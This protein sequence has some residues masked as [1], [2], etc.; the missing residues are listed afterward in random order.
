MVS[1]ET[2]EVLMRRIARGS[3]FLATILIAIACSKSP[4]PPAPDPAAATKSDTEAK[5]NKELALYEQM[6]AAGSIDLAA[7]LGNEILSTYPNTQAAAQVQKTIGDVRDKAAHQAD[8][9]RLSRL[10]TYNAVP[11]AGGT[12]YSAAIASKDALPNNARLRLVL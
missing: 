7:N 11:E 1:K 8:A 4:A 6:R 9:L 3:L 10:W 12:Q 2:T 5:A